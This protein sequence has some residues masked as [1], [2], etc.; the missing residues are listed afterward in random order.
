[1]GF[2]YIKVYFLEIKHLF[3]VVFL[4]ICNRVNFELWK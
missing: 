2:Y 1:M 4:Y 3:G